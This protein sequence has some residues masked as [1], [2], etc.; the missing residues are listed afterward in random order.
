MNTIMVQ[1]SDTQ[2]TMEAMHLASA[3]AR[4]SGGKVILLHLI[5]ANNPGLLGWGIPTPNAAERHHFHECAAVAEDYGVEFCVQPMQFV[6]LTDALAQAAESLNAAILFAH[7]PPSR[8]PI[9]RQ[10]RLWSLKRQLHGCQLYTLDEHQPVSINALV[11][12]S[13]AGKGHYG[14]G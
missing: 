7:I 13:L 1:M 10:Y 9:W 2:W 3:L 5:L 11:E 12:M 14:G 4:S 6:T 8:F